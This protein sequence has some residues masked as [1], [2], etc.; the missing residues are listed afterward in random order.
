MVGLAIAVIVLAVAGWWLGSAVDEPATEP[1][2][3]VADAPEAPD[4]EK[5]VVRRDEPTLEAVTPV[6]SS[7]PLDAAPVEVAEVAEVAKRGGIGTLRV[8]IDAPGRSTG[9]IE[10]MYLMIDG[11]S[12]IVD[13]PASHVV[14]ERLSVGS[15]TLRVGTPSELEPE[16][17]TVRIEKN[18]T[19]EAR[20]RVA[21]P[22]RGRLRVTAVDASGNTIE[23]VQTTITGAGIAARLFTADDGMAATVLPAGEYTV[24]TRH[25]AVRTHLVAGTTREVRLVVRPS[26]VRGV[27]VRSDGRTAAGARIAIRNGAILQVQATADASGQF[28]ARVAFDPPFDVVSWQDGEWSPHVVDDG[29]SSLRLVLGGGGTITGTVV[30]ADGAVALDGEASISRQKD[31]VGSVVER[32]LHSGT[33]TFTTLA[34]GDYTVSVDVDGVRVRTDVTLSAGSQS[35]TTSVQLPRIV[36]L[37]GRL[38]DAITREPVASASGSVIAR[39]VDA[40]VSMLAPMPIQPDA[41]GEFAVRVI[42]GEHQL[43][44]DATPTHLAVNRVATVGDG[45]VDLGDISIARAR[46]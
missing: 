34:P 33:F 46:R 42:K 19:T 36:T 12:R 29:T 43:A 8:T 41:H 16:A 35:T 23:D 4:R 3:V 26:L 28:E 39:P 20:I 17:M 21:P 27:V 13:I 37:R 15:Y 40:R 30:H 18:Q 25:T 1:A 5:A 2:P 22:T 10:A 31:D 7:P 6:E 32:M 14:E 9:D 44:I 45:D 11:S 24:S 38:V